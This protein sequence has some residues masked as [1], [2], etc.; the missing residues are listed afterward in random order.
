MAQSRNSGLVDVPIHSMVM[1]QSVLYVYQRVYPV[2]WLRQ[3]HKPP[4]TGNDKHTTY[5][6]VIWGMVYYW[7]NH[8]A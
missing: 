1:F 2:M 8:I 5:F 6:M 7:F 4:M 3:C